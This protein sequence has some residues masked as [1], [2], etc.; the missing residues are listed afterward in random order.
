[1]QE[2]LTDQLK[3][4]MKAKDKILMNTLRGLKTQLKNEEIEKRKPLSESEELAVFSR[5]AKRRKEAIEQ[6]KQGGRNDLADQEHREMEIILT[7]LPKQ[8]DENEIREIVGQ[9]IEKVGAETLQDMGKVMGA[10][11]QQLKG[12]ADGKI[13]QQIVKEILAS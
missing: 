8:L 3:D 5:E 1:M 9:V 4:A 11:M 13:V 6:Y 7:Y 2:K 10:A 12:K